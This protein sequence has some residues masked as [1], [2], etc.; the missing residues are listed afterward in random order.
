MR[1]NIMSKNENYVVV[2][3]DWRDA[4]GTYLHHLEE[5][6]V[7][8]SKNTVVMGCFSV[9]LHIILNDGGTHVWF[10]EEASVA[11]SMID[12]E[13]VM[14]TM[15]RDNYNDGY[16][17]VPREA[18]RIN[19]HG[20]KLTDDEWCGTARKVQLKKGTE[21]MVKIMEIKK[22]ISSG[23]KTIVIFSDDA[24]V[25]ITDD[26]P[27]VD[28]L[29]LFNKVMFAVIKKNVTSKQFEF[30]C[31]YCSIPGAPTESTIV[32]NKAQKKMLKAFAKAVI[33][34]K[35]FW[36]AWSRYINHLI[37]ELSDKEQKKIFIEQKPKEKR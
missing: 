18:Y 28:S 26:K 11:H 6:G 25:I 21:D 36:P 7:W 17:I 8:H 13:Y 5:K 29:D 22:V 37:Y 12:G 31:D 3:H 14:S 34:D 30:F 23:Q 16:K 27:G 20:A 4:A 19:R 15:I 33:P 24:K 32:N 10:V 1:I 9:G 35:N 2:R